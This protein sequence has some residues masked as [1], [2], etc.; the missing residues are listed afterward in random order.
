MDASD[1]KSA[2]RA[3]GARKSLGQNFMVN[4][5][6]AAMESE[7]ARD[8]SV[9]ELGP[10]L[11]ILTLEL[12]KTARR[13][14]AI[15]K[16]ERLFNMLGSELKSKKLR[17]ING[18]F[19]SMEKKEFDGIDIMVSNIPYSLS[20]KTIYWLGS[21]GIPALI[22]IQREFAEHMLAAPGT[23]S[24]SKL[25]V[26]SALRFRAHL[27]MEVGAN[28]FYPVPN[29][30]SSLV[31]LAPKPGIMDEK[32]AS[33]ISL[34]MG[35]KKKRLRNAIADSAKSL[36]ISK[37]CARL[38]SEKIGH[39]DERPFHMDPETI[40]GVAKDVNRALY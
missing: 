25:S 26:I 37:E 24:Y 15:E 29:V 2:I 11:G 1:Y 14:V 19:F 8:M 4:R 28:N 18:D 31:Y 38:V 23:R 34:I 5:Q 22:C 30:D 40:L 3:L 33:T 35:H 27:V 10:G 9:V 13:V 16:D 20:S 12:C 21:M 39:A 7:Y 32:T 36:G 17:L 6:I